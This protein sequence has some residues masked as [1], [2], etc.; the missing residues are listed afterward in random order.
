MLVCSYCGRNFKN[1]YEVCPGC[2]SHTFKKISSINEMVIKKPPEGGYTIKTT[3]YE[4]SKN[5]TKI[6]K[7]LGMAFIFFMIIFDLPFIISGISL[8][9]EN[10]SFFI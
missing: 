9:D 7:W 8:Y 6:L 5:Y 1:E 3:S 2:G 10:P 4:K